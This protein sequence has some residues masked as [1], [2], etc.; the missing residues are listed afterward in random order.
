MIGL[1][2][3]E[4]HQNVPSRYNSIF[5]FTGQSLSEHYQGSFSETLVTKT[6]PLTFLTQRLMD[7]STRVKLAPHCFARQVTVLWVMTGCKVS[8][9]RPTRRA[10]QNKLKCPFLNAVSIF[11]DLPQL[12]F[13]LPSGLTCLS[14]FSK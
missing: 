10:F 1:I 11:F 13:L 6:H 12:S 14:C 7:V 9:H 2:G 4:F 3:Q 8:L 5:T